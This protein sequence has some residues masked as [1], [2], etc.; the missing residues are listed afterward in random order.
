MSPLS[1]A[2]PVQFMPSKLNSGLMISSCST[3]GGLLSS[4]ESFNRKR[5]LLHRVA[6]I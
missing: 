4:A 1:E 3:M 5:E 2:S 6:T